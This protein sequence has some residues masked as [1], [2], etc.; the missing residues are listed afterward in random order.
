MLIWLNCTLQNSKEITINK[1][2]SAKSDNVKNNSKFSFIP[3][4]ISL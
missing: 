1:S 4:S 3:H 2:V